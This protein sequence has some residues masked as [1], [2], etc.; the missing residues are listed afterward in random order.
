MEY[1]K[2]NIWNI[3]GVIGTFATLFFGIYGLIV[4]PDYVKDANKQKQESANS[5][6]ITDVKEI[7]YSNHKIDGLLVPTLV[8]GKE[9]K[10]DINYSKSNNDVLV[11]V[12]ESFMS[13]KF[14][15]LGQRIYLYNKVDSL[16]RI[17]PE[18]QIVSD[19][20]EIKKSLFSIL[21]YGLSIL[22]LII[23]V[24][25]FYGLI[26]KRKQ[27]IADEIEKKFEEIQEARPESIIDYRNFESLVCDAI[28]QLKLD[29]EDYTKKP[30]D[31]SFDFLI[32]QNGRKIGIEVKSRIRQDVLMN[33]KNRFDKS[34]LDALIII[35]NRL[36]DFS[37]L[38]ML[39]DLN[40]S[41]GIAGRR[42]YFITATTI[43]KLKIEITEILKTE[44]E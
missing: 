8:K 19:K 3:I 24:L 23:S 34:G 14:I 22:S 17:T 39:S 2:K 12:Q 21:T 33:I 11:E 43:D 5:E 28:S 9:I 36:T 40:K 18:I 7:I 10:Y 13:D 15:P 25:L 26:T 35:T 31:F 1:L 29:F 30:K 44:R 20:A 6:I 32:K 42:I 37:T 27:Q 38:S 4:I 16:K 41:T